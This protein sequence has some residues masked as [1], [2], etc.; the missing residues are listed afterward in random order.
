M[1]D[2]ITGVEVKDTP[3]EHS[4]QLFVRWLLSMGFREELIQAHPQFWIRDLKTGRKVYPVDIAVFADGTRDRPAIII[5]CKREGVGFGLD[6]LQKYLKASGARVGIWFDG[7]N[8]THIF[9]TPGAVSYF[10]GAEKSRPD[11][12]G[13]YL[14]SVREAAGLSLR[15]VALKVGADATHLSR[16]ERGTALAS[17][18]LLTKLSATFDQDTY[19][20]FGR[21]GQVP[22]EIETILAM[23]PMLAK[24]VK[25]M[26]N[27][28][29][30][31]FEAVMKQ[32]RD[33]D[34]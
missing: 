13:P 12:F 14:K 31:A 2:T 34:W 3:E 11:A 17:E 24:L 23:R 30:E 9:H 5:E 29:D 8:L 19:E 15:Q 26:E 10:E 16:I 27:A 22:K 25:A 7:T 32:V 20:F 21:A 1:K 18:E 28:P 6:Q 33:G 4:V